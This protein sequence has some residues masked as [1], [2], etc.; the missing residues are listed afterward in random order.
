[1]SSKDALYDG[2]KYPIHKLEDGESAIMRWPDLAACASIFADDSDLPPGLDPEFLMRYLILLYTPG[3]PAIDQHHHLGKRKTW[4]LSQL[5]VEPDKK[6]QEYEPHINNMILMRSGGVRKKMVT[7]LRLQHPT[8]WSIMCH[9]EQDLFELLERP[10]PA[11]PDDAAKQRK[12]I[13]DTRK[14][15]IQ[16]QERILEHVKIAGIENAVQSFRAQANLGIRMEEIVMMGFDNIKPHLQTADRLFPE[17][18][19]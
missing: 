7:F 5:G 18:G 4:V 6:T 15:L 2:F 8:D 19:N 14:Q 11:E 13:E 1:M 12:L 10:M 17:V 3:S 16:A 9:A